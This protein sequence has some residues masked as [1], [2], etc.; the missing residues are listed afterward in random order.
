MGCSLVSKS[1]LDIIY[2][3]LNRKVDN[4]LSITLRCKYNYPQVIQCYPLK[5]NKPFPTLYWVTCPY[6]VEVVSKLESESLIATLEKKVF[7]NS[8]LKEQLFQ[9]HL[10]EIKKRVIILGDQI[11][12]L[13][14]NIKKKIEESGIGG[15]ADF[16]KIK[17]L[18]M[19]LASFLSKEP[20]PIGQIVS[21][22]ISEKN[23]LDERCKSFIS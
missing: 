9:A 11:E 20:N 17:C 14:R 1:D 22:M 8:E 7:E 21:N 2:N 5:D 10:E 13:P 4:I 18:H 19:H 12:Q 16:N 23:C 3:Q 15:T 6:L